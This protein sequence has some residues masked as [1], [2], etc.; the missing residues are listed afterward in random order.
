MCCGIGV[1]TLDKERN[2]YIC[3]AGKILKTTGRLVEHLCFVDITD[4]HHF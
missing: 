3:S 4:K 2:V 1:L